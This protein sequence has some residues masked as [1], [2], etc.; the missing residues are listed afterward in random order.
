M[1]VNHFVSNMGVGH[2]AMVACDDCDDEL[3]RLPQPNNCLSS[4]EGA[5]SAGCLGSTSRLRKHTS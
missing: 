4:L 2:D 1:N 3:L 5:G